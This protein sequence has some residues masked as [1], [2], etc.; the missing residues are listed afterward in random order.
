MTKGSNEE[1]TME[2]EARKGMGTDEAQFSVESMLEQSY[3]W[4]DKYRP[5]KPRYNIRHFPQTLQ[6]HGRN[7]MEIDHEKIINS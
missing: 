1:K 6:K 4:S 3:D 7:H 2:A 5:R